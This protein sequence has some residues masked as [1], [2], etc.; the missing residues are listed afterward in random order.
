MKAH[1]ST[2]LDFSA[3]NPYATLDKNGDLLMSW[4]NSTVP[5]SHSAEISWQRRSTDGGKTWATDYDMKLGKLGGTLL[6]PGEG[7]V[8]GRHAPQSQYKGRIVICGLNFALKMMY[9]ALKLMEFGFKTMD[10]VFKL[11]GATGYVGNIPGGQSMPVFT[12]DDDG[13]T[14]QTST[15]KG[16][17]PKAPG[18]PSGPAST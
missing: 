15:G 9:S 17:W 11:T 7:I 18:F 16:D 3:R 12:S 5:T 1:K 14:Y 4:V 8:L 6:G 10:F 13:K 2:G